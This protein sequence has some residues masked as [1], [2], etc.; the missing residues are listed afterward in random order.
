M[1]WPNTYITTIL[2]KKGTRLCSDIKSK[3]QTR[4]VFR[5]KS[6]REPT[7]QP[8]MPTTSL[9]AERSTTNQAFRGSHLPVSQEEQEAE[10]ETKN[11]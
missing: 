4:A 2:T 8:V 1:L 11:I 9:T 5:D 6:G 3:A 7:W 10:A